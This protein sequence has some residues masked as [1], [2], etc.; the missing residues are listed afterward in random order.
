MKCQTVQSKL[1][2]YLD[3][4]LAASARPDERAQIRQHLDDC[5]DCRDQ[6]QR[7]RKMAVLLSRAPRVLPPAGLAVRIKVAA[8]QSTPKLTWR[9]RWQAAR[10][11]MEILLDNVF[12]PISLPATGG[13]F[14][15]M[16]IFLLVLQMIMPGINVEAVA[17]DVPLNI[18]QPAELISLSDYPVTWGPEPAE[19]SSP[20][21]LVDVTVDAQ[22]QMVAYEIL[23]G[24]SDPVTRHE[25]D[26]MLIFSRFRPMLSFGR[27]T[28]GGHVILNLDSVQVRG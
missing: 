1:A 14:S 4:A 25:L 7:Y 27:P 28:S 13:F 21:L 26:Q 24:P 11:R 10:D 15:A 17:N 6:L 22:G 8:L 18:L 2:G 16:I 23:A 5:S 20:G 9:N 19:V 3:D 12:R